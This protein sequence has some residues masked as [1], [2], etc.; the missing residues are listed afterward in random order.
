MIRVFESPEAL[1]ASAA[2]MIARLCREAEPRGRFAM[3]L[4]GGETP[5]RT[6]QLLAE[7]PLRDEVPWEIVHVFWGDERA[8]QPS[9]RRSNERMAREALLDRVPIPREQIHPIRCFP[10]ARDAA[11]SYE[12]QLRRFFQGPPRFDIA[13]LGLGAD[14]HTASLMPGS[15]ALEERE[16]WTAVVQAYPLDRVTLTA[17]ALDQAARI[18]FLVSGYAKARALHGV[19]EGP[20]AP[21]RLPAQLIR[22]AGGELDWLVD[23]D[24]ASQLGEAA[25]ANA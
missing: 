11:W 25:Q 3:A 17:P 16:R 4:A 10:D 18:V 21:H 8:V 14:G 23:R 15:H 2:G 20:P 19:L 9:D 6:Y 12:A 7:P 22:P 1:S 13:L 5:R 24:A